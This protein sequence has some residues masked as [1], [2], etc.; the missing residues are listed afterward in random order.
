[1]TH[2]RAEAHD[3][4]FFSQRKNRRFQRRLR[5]SFDDY[6][7][8]GERRETLL[9][10][11]GGWDAESV[12]SGAPGGRWRRPS[13]ATIRPGTAARRLS[14][15]QPIALPAV[16]PTGPN[17]V[18]AE[19]IL[20]AVETK[21]TFS[22]KKVEFLQA[23]EEKEK[24][25]LAEKGQK[26][27]FSE[28]KFGSSSVLSNLS[29]FLYSISENY[30]VSIPVELVDNI[31]QDYKQLASDVVV[32]KREWQTD[33]Y[34]DFQV[35]NK[36]P[37]LTA[38]PEEVDVREKLESS[39]RKIAKKQEKEKNKRVRLSRESMWK[40]CPPDSSPERPQTARSVL[41][42]FSFHSDISRSTSVDERQEYD[43]LPAE[44]RPTILHYRRESAMPRGRSTG[45]KTRLE[46]FKSMQRGRTGD[47]TA[48]S[49]DEGA[50]WYNLSLVTAV[51]ALLYGRCIVV[52]GMVVSVPDPPR[53]RVWFRDYWHGCL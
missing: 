29:K 5:K 13:S 4:Y 46:K 3:P 33:C 31:V 26:Y 22:E 38:V 8:Y 7:L 52:T 10:F 47:T 42:N 51:Y 49:E 39:I 36:R 18:A 24:P 27:K 1:M 9:T 34:L 11:K 45:P 15:K 19:S 14:V 20:E 23:V 37:F 25:N 6:S 48:K 28:A 35:K 41:S 30:S 44:L 21:S 17:L 2:V 40:K 43:M 32:E 16:D 53:A 12:V 50:F